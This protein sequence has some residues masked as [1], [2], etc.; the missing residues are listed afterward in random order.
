[1]MLRV[2]AFVPTL[3]LAGLAAACSLTAVA[4]AKASVYV[5]TGEMER[6]FW[7]SFLAGAGAILGGLAIVYGMLDKSKT[8]EMRTLIQANADQVQRNAE[9]IGDILEMFKQHH[10]D[11]DAHPRGSAARIN[12]IKEALDELRDKQNEIHLQ[13]AGLV[14]EHHQIRAS[15]DNLC[16]VLSRRDPALS[17]H[18]RRSTD[19]TDFDGR[20]PGIRG[21][22]G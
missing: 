13:L 3:L 22:R 9:Q 16:K 8:S 18:P 19:P 20:L 4:Q 7:T 11:E 5:T 15:E 6:Y 17:P 1:M 14:A 2:R 21:T 10:L 12:P